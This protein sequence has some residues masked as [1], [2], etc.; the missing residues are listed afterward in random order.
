[1]SDHESWNADHPS[2]RTYDVG[3]RKPPKATRF[4]PGQSGNPGGRRRASMSTRSSAFE[5]LLDREIAISTGD[6]M[7]TRSLEEAL[8]LRTYQEALKGKAMAIR[9][10]IGWILKREAWFAK[11]QPQQRR[12]VVFAGT[13]Q[14]PDNAD[15][16]LLL[17]NIA[18]IN[19]ARH[20]PNAKRRQLLLEPWVVNAALR[21][22]GLAGSLETR[23]VEN[24]RRCTRDDG[25]ITW[26]DR[27][28]P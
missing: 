5:T 14:D 18:G 9:E 19:P 22:R 24:I 3:Y 17:L 16:V 12:S 26:P 25:S 20:L 28:A 4:K 13:R 8:Q 27:V 6:R 2:H 1:M 10:V 23:Q 7:E 11:H 21:K 15:E